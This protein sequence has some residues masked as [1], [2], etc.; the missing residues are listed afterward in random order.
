MI[1]KIT[2]QFTMNHFVSLCLIV[3]LN[4][5]TQSEDQQMHFLTQIHVAYLHVKNSPGLSLAFHFLS[6][7]DN[8]NL[9]N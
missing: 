3:V 4:G 6:H 8:Y 7:I 5:E 9:T 2:K 1:V